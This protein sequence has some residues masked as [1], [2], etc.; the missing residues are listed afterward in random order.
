MTIEEMQKKL[1][2][3]RQGLAELEAQR[4]RQEGAILMLQELL[5]QAQQ[6]EEAD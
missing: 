5:V 3:L 1:E 2:E 6:D 4:L